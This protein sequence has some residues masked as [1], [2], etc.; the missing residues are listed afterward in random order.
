VYYSIIERGYIEGQTLLAKLCRVLM[1]VKGC[2][3]KCCQEQQQ[4]AGSD[5]VKKL[6]INN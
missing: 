2:D 4:A 3:H 1:G 5:Y 6:M